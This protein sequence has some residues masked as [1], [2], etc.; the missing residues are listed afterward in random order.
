[1]HAGQHRTAMGTLY[2]RPDDVF[3]SP[4]AGLRMLRGLAWDIISIRAITV[5]LA[6]TTAAIRGDLKAFMSERGYTLEREWDLCGD[7]EET[8]LTELWFVQP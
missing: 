3:A 2:G 1:M 7:P 6:N 4:D 5:A 8:R